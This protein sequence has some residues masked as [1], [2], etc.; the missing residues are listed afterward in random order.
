V[1]RLCSCLLSGVRE[2]KISFKRPYNT[3]TEMAALI[4]EKVPS[5]IATTFSSFFAGGAQVFS[6]HTLNSIQIT[7]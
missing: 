7:L 4:E 5:L 3:F 1:S 6:Y 2:K